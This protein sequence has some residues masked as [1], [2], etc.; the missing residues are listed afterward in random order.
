MVQVVGLVAA[1]AYPDTVYQNKKEN[2]PPAAAG[3]LA[4]CVVPVVVSDPFC[5][6][7]RW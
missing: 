1:V 2:L 5:H 7:P 4:V 3:Q 6:R